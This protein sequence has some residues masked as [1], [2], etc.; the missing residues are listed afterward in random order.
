MCK[1]IHT[2]DQATVIRSNE[3]NTWRFSV[4]RVINVKEQ[5]TISAA[6]TALANAAASLSDKDRDR[7]MSSVSDAPSHGSR[8]SIR[9]LQHENKNEEKRNDKG[10][11][12]RSEK[13][14]EMILTNDKNDN[15]DDDIHMDDDDDDEE[16]EEEE[17]DDEKEE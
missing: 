7:H 17:E 10:T 1:D 8:K 15:I 2:I 5:V 12:T 16:E 4:S 3:T 14:S 9:N 13:T 11:G 6:E